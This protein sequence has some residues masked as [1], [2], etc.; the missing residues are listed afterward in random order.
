MTDAEVHIGDTAVDGPEADD[1]EMTGAENAAN[2]STT[3]EA[4]AVAE[5]GA[6]EEETG[7]T[8]IQ[9]DEPERIT[10]LE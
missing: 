2:D 5:T 3:A 10:F 7:L 9:A 4:G 1:V 6:T 8:T